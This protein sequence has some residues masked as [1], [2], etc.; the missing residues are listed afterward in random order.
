MHENANRGIHT[1]LV[2]PFDADGT[3]RLDT[4][5]ALCERQIDAGIHGLVACG[6][7]GETPTLDGEEW[8][9]VVKTAV[10]VSAGRV[11]VMAGVGTNSTRSTV[12]NVRAAKELGADTGLLV[13]PYYNKPNPEGHR[14]HVRAALAEG[15]P[16]VLYHVPGRTGQRLDPALVAELA[17]FDGVVGVKEATGDLRFGGDVLRRTSTNVL[18]GDDFTFL[19]LLAQ[20]GAGCVSVISNVAPAE[21]VAVYEHFVAGRL[22]EATAQFRALWDLATFLFSDSNPVP[23]KAC[24]AEMG[25][26]GPHPRGPLAVYDGPSPRPILAELGLL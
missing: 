16:L 22:D 24:L 1:A 14:A 25:V 10:D 8:T 18:S 6:T 12:A 13:F 11:P 23:A 19:G 4:F 5:A 2:T 21:T 3:L 15:L 7:T 20:G 17:S 26:C 9:Q